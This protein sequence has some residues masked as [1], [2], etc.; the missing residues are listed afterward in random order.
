MRDNRGDEKRKQNKIITKEKKHDNLDDYEKEQLKKLK[1]KERKQCMIT[2][3]MIKEKDQERKK[4][5]ITVT[6]K[7]NDKKEKKDKR[8]N[9]DDYEKEQL[10]DMRKNERKKYVITLIMIKKY[11]Q[12][13]LRKG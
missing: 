10:K 9:L 5:M 3:V 2:L 1:E 4:C 7:K 12:K 8:N 13:N 11:S 6:M